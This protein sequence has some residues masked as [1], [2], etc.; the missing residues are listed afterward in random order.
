VTSSLAGPAPGWFDRLVDA[1]KDLAGRPIE[2][3]T[4]LDGRE[5][6]RSVTDHQ[7]RDSGGALSSPSTFDMRQGFMPAGTAPP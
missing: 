2:V 4:H 6:A 3:T 1:I 5:I 7:A